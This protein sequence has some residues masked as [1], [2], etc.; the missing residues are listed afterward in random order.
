M[1]TYRFR[2]ECGLRNN[3]VA[4]V[5]EQGQRTQQV[6]RRC[7]NFHKEKSCDER[8]NSVESAHLNGSRHCLVYLSTNH[9]MDQCRYTVLSSELK[10][11]KETNFLRGLTNVATIVC[12]REHSVDLEFVREGSTQV[13][14]LKH[15]FAQ[16]KLYRKVKRLN[17][18]LGVKIYVVSHF[19]RRISP[20]RLDGG[21]DGA[22][23]PGKDYPPKLTTRGR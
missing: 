8:P 5:A 11:L 17:P 10:K 1:A 14:Q 18:I 4:T 12:A 13:V 15:W 7:P 23:S 22:L 19:S 16:K 9:N 3:F 21:C 2:G 6:F 20:K